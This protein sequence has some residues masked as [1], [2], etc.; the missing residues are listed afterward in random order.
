VS[1]AEKGDEAQLDLFFFVDDRAA[2]VRQE[3]AG[4]VC[5]DFGCPHSRDYRF[6]VLLAHLS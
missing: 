1:F 5:D 3:R 6:A 4:D 2:H